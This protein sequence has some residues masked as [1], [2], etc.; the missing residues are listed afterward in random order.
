MHFEISKEQTSIRASVVREL[1]ASRRIDHIRGGFSN[2]FS[3]STKVVFMPCKLTRYKRGGEKERRKGKW[4]E[5]E[6]VRHTYNVCPHEV[7]H[8][9]HIERHKNVFVFASFFFFVLF[10]FIM[11][12]LFVCRYSNLPTFLRLAGMW[13]CQ[14]CMRFFF[15]YA[16][17]FIAPSIP[18]LNCG[19]SLGFVFFFLRLCVSFF[20]CY[21]SFRI[22]LQFS[23]LFCLC[24][25]FISISA[26]I[27]HLMFKRIGS[28]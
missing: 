26:A 20:C 11:C 7:H 9:S 25:G 6:R 10:V 12:L 18:R 16:L 2:R 28:I 3:K 8:R 13:F 1:T 27:K 15:F 5:N 14:F 4:R 22:D 17:T 19:L 24:A 23:E 21:S